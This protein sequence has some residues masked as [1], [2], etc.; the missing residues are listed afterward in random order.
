MQARLFRHYEQI[1]RLM[2]YIITYDNWL[3]LT[4]FGLGLAL[5]FS[6]SP[7]PPPLI[8]FMNTPMRSNANSSSFRTRVLTE[9]ELSIWNQSGFLWTDTSSPNLDLC[10]ESWYIV[11]SPTQFVLSRARP[12]PQSPDLYF[13]NSSTFDVIQ[14]VSESPKTTGIAELSSPL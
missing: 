7:P 13:R 5:K 10:S 4:W 6:G 1:S 12:I 11:P 9:S 8:F 2:A 3:G 14:A